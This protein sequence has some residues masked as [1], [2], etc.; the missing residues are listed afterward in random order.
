MRRELAYSMYFIGIDIGTSSVKAACLEDGRTRT[1]RAVY[2]PELGNTPAGWWRAVCEAVS[3]AAREAGHD[4]AGLGLTAQVGTYILEDSSRPEDSWPV[5]SWSG[6]GGETQREAL[7]TRFGTE[8]FLEHTGMPLP[9]VPSYPASR[10]RWLAEER[11][12]EWSRATH[13][14]APKDFL[15]RKLTGRLLSDRLSWNGLS[16]P[17][18]GDP[19]EA[20]L[21]ALELDG[22]LF[23]PMHEPLSAPAGLSHEAAA[24]LGLPAGTPVY[25]GCNDSHA[26]FLGMGVCGIGQAFDLTGTS[27]HV[28]LISPGPLGDGE[29][30]CSPFFSGCATFGVTASSGT[31]LDWGFG[32]TGLPQNRETETLALRRFEALKR[33]EAHPPIFLPYVT[34]ER[35]PIWDGDA[36]GAFLG[37]SDRH[38][39]ED[40]L[41]SVFE[42]VVFSV[43][44]IWSGLPEE[45]TQS[46]TNIRMGGGAG[47]NMLMNRMKAACLQRTL[48]IPR[49]KN[50]G[51]L[52]AGL[53]AAAGSGAYASLGDA[54]RDYVSLTGTVSPSDDPA[55]L[56]RRFELY[57]RLSGLNRAYGICASL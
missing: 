41:Y 12:A 10:L 31:S 19:D 3:E 23:A 22:G 11:T 25:L 6:P 46:V 29:M 7:Q 45:L 16:N 51:A 17:A 43:A 55:P 56:L 49:E 4:C 53:I 5:Y 37:L 15:Y 30:I 1:C 42:G 8:F 21:S 32:I 52:G 14:L 47:E 27:E 9:K 38:T 20:F 26:S 48:E 24:L 35:T 33:G 34:G 2:S 39:R 50:T 18:H 28:G 13:V 54:V 44:H 57:R 36:R 40:L